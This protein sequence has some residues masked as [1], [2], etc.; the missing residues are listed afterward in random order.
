MKKLATGQHE[1]AAQRYVLFT[2]VSLNPGLGIGVGAYLVLPATFLERSAEDIE[3]PETARQVVVKRFEET[4]STR[5]EVQTAL[6]ALEEYRKT[7]G[8]SGEGALQ[9]FTDSQCIAGLLRRRARLERTGY[10]ST[11]TNRPIRNAG[12]YRMFYEFFDRFGFEVVKVPGHTRTS[13]R[14]TVDHVF[15]MV[16]KAARKALRDVLRGR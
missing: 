2:D 15:S 13:A 11:R 4:S 1:G 7:H 9:V 16:D 12:L 8:G 6:W 10:S 3:K 5:L 14:D